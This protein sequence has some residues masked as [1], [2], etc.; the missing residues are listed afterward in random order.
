MGSGSPFSSPG[1]GQKA[2]ARMARGRLGLRLLG[3]SGRLQNFVG[4]EGDK[5]VGERQEPHRN[6][7]NGGLKKDLSTS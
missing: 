7:M 1:M 5:T 4:A 3:S 2:A 6:G